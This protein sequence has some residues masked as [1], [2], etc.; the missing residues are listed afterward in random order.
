MIAGLILAAGAS[1]RMGRTKQTLPFAGGTLLG[2][3]VRVAR[4][5]AGCVVVVLGAAADEIQAAGDLGDAIVVL[6]ADH[7]EG[8]AA[9]L[10]AG[11]A[12]L[13]EMAAIDAAVVALGDQPTLRP[14]AW[15]QVIAAYQT[16][17]APAVTASYGGR[18]GHPILFARSAWPDLMALRGDAGARQLLDAGRIAPLVVVPLPAAWYPVDV[19]TPDEYRSLL[20]GEQQRNDDA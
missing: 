14:D 12:A 9:S 13:A 4:G 6:A 20:A 1:R 18:R 3:A 8:Q 19:D 15:A 11:L 10:R 2:A 5:Q 17:G 7:Q 16:T